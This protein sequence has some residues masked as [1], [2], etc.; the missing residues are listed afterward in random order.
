MRVSRRR[1]PHFYALD[2]PVFV[3]FRLHGS[4]P[5]NRFFRSG[6]LSSGEVF[7]ALDRLLDRADHGPRWL[8]QEPIAEIIEQAIHHNESALGHYEL[9]SYVIMANHVHMLITPHVDLA[10][11]FRSL[12]GIT[13]RRANDYL[14]L[15]GPFWQEESYDHVVRNQREFDRIVGYIEWNPIK[16]ELVKTAEAYRWSS[17]WRGR[18]PAADLGVRPTS[19]LGGPPHTGS[20]IS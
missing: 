1:L 16:A 10:R 5:E 9:H 18:G 14:K 11:I 6:D 3:T 17:A 20:G 12:K 15:D 8:M 2:R 19:E 13:A 4:L 7:V